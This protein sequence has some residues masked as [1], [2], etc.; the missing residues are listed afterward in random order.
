MD[1]CQLSE[2]QATRLLARMT[3]AGVLIA[4]GDKRWRTYEIGSSEG[5]RK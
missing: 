3:K 5:T 4:K 1:L 2:D